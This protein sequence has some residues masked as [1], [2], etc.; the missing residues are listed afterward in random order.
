MTPA[1]RRTSC[2]SI[3][4]RAQ[5]SAIGTSRK[6]WSTGLELDRVRRQEGLVDLIFLHEHGQ[7]R[8]KQQGVRPGAYG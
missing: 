8:G 3:P 1:T 6:T 4:L 5:H 7:D 2:S